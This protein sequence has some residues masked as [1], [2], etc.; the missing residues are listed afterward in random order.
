MKALFYLLCAAL[1]WVNYLYQQGMGPGPG[2]PHSSGVIS[3]SEIQ[4]PKGHACTSAASCSVTV[5]ST[6]TAH[7]I[8]VL[9]FYYNPSANPTSVTSVHNAFA[10]DVCTQNINA[11][12]TICSYSTCNSVSGDTSITANFPSNFASAIYVGE[13]AHPTTTGCFDQSTQNSLSGTTPWSSGA[14]GTTTQANELL[15]GWNWDPTTYNSTFVGTGG[16]TLRLQEY[17]TGSYYNSGLLTQIVTS[18]GAYSATGTTSGG[19][20]QNFPGLATYK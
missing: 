20:D 7:L 8:P 14:A 9:V 19:S 5:T 17:D 11:H 12:A 1:V 16:W 13:Y 18:T 4:T 3:I 2:M 10:Q 15:W 6:G